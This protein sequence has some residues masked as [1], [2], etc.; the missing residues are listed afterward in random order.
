[1]KYFVPASPPT[2]ISLWKATKMYNESEA[3][4]RQTKSMN[5]LVAIAIRLIPRPVV[6]RRIWK[7]TCLRLSISALIFASAR[8]NESVS[9][10]AVTLG[11]AGSL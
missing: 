5:R 11:R 9:I 7:S 10:G 4:S 8:T 2:S 3:S 1:M 6:T